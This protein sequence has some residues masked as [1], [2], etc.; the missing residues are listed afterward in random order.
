M[1]E[2]FHVLMNAVD[3]D[4]LEEAMT[5]VTK[6]KPL[7]W[8]GIAVA[9]CL[10]L[11]MGFGLFPSNGPA[12]T[13]VQ[14]TEMGYDMKLPENAEQVSYEIVTL[15]GQEGAQASFRI[16]DTKYVY[17]AVK[18]QQELQLSDM[19]ADSQV[20]SWNAGDLDI[21]L[22]ASSSGTSVSWYTSEN[23]TQWYLTAHADAMKVL[24]TASQILRAT[25]LDVTVAPEDAEDITYNVFLLDEL[26]VAETTFRIDGITYAYRMAAT[27][28]LEEDFADISGLTGSFDQNATGDV[29][30]CGA[31]ISFQKG[32]AGKIIW[33]D[34]VP[35]ILYSLSVDSGAS[36]N[37]LLEMANS[38]F[39]PAQDN[40]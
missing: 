38:L 15:A 11:A 16:Q 22:R 23:Q 21:Q 6:R 33:F 5:P 20:I 14:L 8:I 18:T 31:K 29:Y 40:N 27:L 24:T 17:Q 1:S 25:G 3:E 19:E 36:E 12:V 30:W 26:T 9:A 10:L 28:E 35:G 13:V 7:G 39:E 2:K 32:G 34:L 4:L 37:M